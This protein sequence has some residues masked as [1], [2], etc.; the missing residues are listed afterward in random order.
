MHYLDTILF[1]TEKKY[2]QLK[3]RIKKGVRQ[4][5]P[6]KEKYQ[7]S[8]IESSTATSIYERLTLCMEKERLFLNPNLKLQDVADAIRCSSGEISQTLNI[9]MNTNFTDFVNQYRIDEFIRQVQEDTSHKYT[10]SSLSEQCGFSS[11]TSFFRSFK[12]QKGMSPAEYIKIHI[13]KS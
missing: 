2:H 1:Q 3:I 10:L 4:N 7:K 12:K 6:E 9:F 8:K 11:R 13:S 5:V